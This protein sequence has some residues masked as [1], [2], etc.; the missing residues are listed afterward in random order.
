MNRSD[1]LVQLVSKAFR[2]YSRDP[3][4]RAY[5]SRHLL[6]AAIALCAEHNDLGDVALITAETLTTLKQQNRMTERSV[7]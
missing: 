2:K 7:G 4:V 5:S 3:D 6:M 1:G